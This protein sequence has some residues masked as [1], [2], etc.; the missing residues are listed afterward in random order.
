MNIFHDKY[1]LIA[2]AAILV[3]SAVCL[4]DTVPETSSDTEITGIVSDIRNTQSG[5]TFF[6][7]DSSGTATK[8]FHSGEITEGSVCSVSGRFS[9]DGS[10]LFASR[11]TVR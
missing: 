8:C 6:I 4:T 2:I 3:V 5:F 7:T 9:D 11:V 1:V 10:I